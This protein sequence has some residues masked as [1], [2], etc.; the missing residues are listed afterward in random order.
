LG[1]LEDPHAPGCEETLAE[2][3]ARNDEEAQ[4]RESS[5]MPK[6]ITAMKRRA[7]KLRKG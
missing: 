2:E 3:D 7:T 1:L 6:I 5:P 4:Q